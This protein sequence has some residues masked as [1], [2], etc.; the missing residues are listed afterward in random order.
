MRQMEQLQGARLHITGVVQGVGFRPFVY[1]LALRH[2]LKGWVRNTSAGVDIQVDGTLAALGQFIEQ[3]RLEA[4]PL[5]HIDRIEHEFCPADGFS[6]FE[7]VSSQPVPGAFQPISADVCVC[8]ECLAETLDPAS[9]RYRYPFTNCTNCGPRFTIINDIPYDRPLTTMSG[10]SMCP[11]CAAEYTN[12]LDRR[13]H[14]QPIA[15]PVCG[16]QIWLEYPANHPHPQ[17]TGEPALQQAI[18]ML[19]K[20]KILAIKGLGGFHLACDALNL[21]AVTSLRQRKLRVDKP[22]A[23]M[24]PDLATIKLHCFV[25]PEEQVLLESNQRPIVILRR[26]EDSPIAQAVA[27]GQNT[28][29]VMLPYTPLHY[30][31]FTPIPG[32]TETQPGLSALVMTSGNLSEEP[33]AIDNDE[34]RQRLASLAD[35]F[36][37]HDRPIRTRCDDSVVRIY[38]VSVKADLSELPLRRSRGYAPYPVH[39]PWQAPSIL[40]FGAELK[41][42]FCITRQ[43][44]AFLSHHIGDLE[45]YETLRSFED[46]VQHF[47]HLFRIKPDLLACDLHPDYMATRY[48]MERSEREN[49]PAFRIQ[50]HHAHIAA[51]MLE[52]GLF[53]EQPVIGV[54]FDGTG[55]G[56][57][58]AIWGGE[59]LIA[60]YRGY[61]RPYHLA[62][63]R[64]P[65]G[66]KAIHEPWRMALA[67]LHRCGL[68]WSESLAPMVHLQR[69]SVNPQQQLDALANQLRSGLN[70]SPTSSMGR[71][72][73]AVSALIGVRQVANYEAQA[74]IEFEAL[75]DTDEN[76]YYHF[77][78]EAGEIDPAPVFAAILDDLDTGVS[79]A[80]ISARFHNAVGRMVLAICQALRTRYDIDQV[81]L[82]GGVWQN[83][84]LLACL[85]PLLRREKFQVYFHHLVPPNDGGIAL[86]QAAIAA[87]QWKNIN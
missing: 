27:P 86:G 82:S 46:G 9:R 87:Q 5:A 75:S 84:T 33:I 67:W 17:S 59:F 65:G 55:Y 76:G 11:D 49:L 28:L 24:L 72:F 2:N 15:C 83:V 29:G 50:H 80:L 43:E 14:A 23:L 66:D 20:G 77:G 58:G 39:I 60:D 12:P 16:P 35:A 22:F 18:H 56:D 52:N 81:C 62:Y 32:E 19:R 54:S 57:D 70:A 45:N 85:V 10:F 36:L 4:P 42:T 25:S 78:I 51:C 63:A 37:L 48:A 53:G 34:A 13:Y 79:K 44:Y 47:E 26:R 64:L 41:N 71:L 68:P 40:A 21:P 8:P 7:I 73:D 30:L 69:A 38:P 61:Q 74:A 3:L 1:T 6:T 31:L